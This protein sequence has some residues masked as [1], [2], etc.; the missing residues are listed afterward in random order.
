MTKRPEPLGA[1][2]SRQVASAT[3]AADAASITPR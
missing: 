1:G 2:L 3:E